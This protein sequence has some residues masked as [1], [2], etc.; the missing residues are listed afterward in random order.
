MNK[1]KAIQIGDD[2]MNRDP[3]KANYGLFSGGSS[4]LDSV[5][6]F[7]WFE[8]I[9]ELIHFITKAEPLIFD[10]DAEAIKKYEDEITPILEKVHKDGLT[11]QIKNQA[12]DISSDFMIIDWWGSFSELVTVRTEFS[13]DLI[14]QF[15]DN[16]DEKQKTLTEEHIDEFIKFIQSYGY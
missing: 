14:E 12:N 4:I 15:F 3:R 11:N 10:L 2:A 5:R 8:T 9:E 16:W 6:V 1:E 13:N 7:M